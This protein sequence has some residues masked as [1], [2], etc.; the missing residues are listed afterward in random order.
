[1]FDQTWTWAGKYRTT[2]KNLG[3]LFHQ[4]MNEIAAILGNCHYW[5]EHETFDP[6]EI[7]IRFHHR[8]VWIHPFPNG[9]GRHARLL[10][11]VIAVKNSRERFTWGSATLEAAGSGRAEYIRCLQA[12][13]V[14]NDDIQGLLKFA[15]S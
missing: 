7:A 15:R 8:L 9:N 10:A 14:N 12:A 3:V 1:M 6:D 13:D 4:I 11:D 5:I 2:N